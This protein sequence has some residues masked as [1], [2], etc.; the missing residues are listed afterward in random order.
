MREACENGMLPLIVANVLSQVFLVV[1][2]DQKFHII[3]FCATSILVSFESKHLVQD[4]GGNVLQID[5]LASKEPVGLRHASYD[6][7]A[8][9][10]FPYETIGD[11]VLV[12]EELALSETRYS[13]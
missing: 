13:V 12:F 1:T 6:D 10:A 2:N 5:D 7:I 9:S 8:V 3:Q 4:F 11:F